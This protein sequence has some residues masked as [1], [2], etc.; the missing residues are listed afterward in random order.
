MMDLSG[1]AITDKYPMR[2]LC[3]KRYDNGFA[4]DSSSGGVPRT[5]FEDIILV[6][7][8]SWIFLIGLVGLIV[9]ALNTMRNQ[10]S[11]IKSPLHRLVYRKKD[12]ATLHD[13][14]LLEKD[15]KVSNSPSVA[16]ANTWGFKHT[17][18]ASTLSILYS[19]LVAATLLMS[20]YPCSVS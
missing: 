11:N 20:E 18:L 19:L 4:F 14:G 17:K 15:G 10:S 7:L 12:A 6:P 8:A 1:T 9:F 2:A 3:G 16:S 5:C 13:D